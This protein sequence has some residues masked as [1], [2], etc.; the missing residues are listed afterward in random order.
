[1]G[2]LILGLLVATSGAG[3]IAAKRYLGQY[4]FTRWSEMR[5]KRMAKSAK[6]WTDYTLVTGILIIAA[7]VA[8]AAVSLY[9][10]LR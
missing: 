6:Y 10:L 8:I 4:T 2:G 1:M 3:L 9:G 7:G 5:S